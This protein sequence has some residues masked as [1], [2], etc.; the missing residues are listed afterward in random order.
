[1]WTVLHVGL[2]RPPVQRSH[3]YTGSR[4]PISCGSVPFMEGLAVVVYE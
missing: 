4:E 1:M 3:Q 2:T